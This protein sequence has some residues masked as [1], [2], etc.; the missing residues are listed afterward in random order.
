VLSTGTAPPLILRHRLPELGESVGAIDNRYPGWDA[1]AA[2]R[3]MFCHY[4]P[5]MTSA[6]WQLLERAAD[7]CGAPRPLAVA[8]TTTSAPITVP[9]AEPGEMIF[10]RV[11]G[12]EVTGAESIRTLLYRARERTVSF[13]GGPTWRVVPAT[14]GDGLLLRLPRAADFPGRFGLAPNAS[15]FE[16]VIDGV[17][18]RPLTVEFYSQPVDEGP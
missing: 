7:R 15:R 1:P 17:S 10:A 4:K 12:L 16:F 14:S 3:S 18:A 2:M 5:V 13:D 6:R 11:A 9:G 8:H